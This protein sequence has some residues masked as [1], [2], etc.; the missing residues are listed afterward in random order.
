M[1]PPLA[2]TA[3][4]GPA[5]NP[6]FA[7][8]AVLASFAEL[9]LGRL[10]LELPDG[11]VVELGAAVATA[12]EVAPGVGSHALIRV[13]RPAFF[14]K[15]L[16][17]GDVG[18]AEAFIDGDWETPDLTAVVGWFVLNVETAPTLS[19][20]RRARAFALNVLG[21]VN[22]LGHWLR[23]NTR[24]MAR[25][26]IREHYDL[27]NEFFALW[28]DPTMMYS[29]AR[30]ERTDAALHEAQA[31]KNEALCRKLRLQPSDHVLEIGTGWGGWSL[32]AA[33]HYG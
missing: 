31:A 19:G 11:A 2:A 28:L 15:C 13:R 32:H 26:N 22:R 3:T 12:R 5:R 21:I 14:T 8:R 17:S 7:E 1:S 6:T 33:Q 27:S 10:R 24:A 20:S 23:A 18:F 9:K 4:A 25:R 29:C 16:V 30:W